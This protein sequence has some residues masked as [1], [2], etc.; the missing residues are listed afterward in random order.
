MFIT[1]RG[2]KAQIGIEIVFAIGITL[3]IFILFI[4]IT[5]NKRGDVSESADLLSKHN[6]C[7]TFINIVARVATTPNLNVTHYFSHDISVKANNR[8]IDIDGVLCTS[9]APVPDKNLIKGLVE[10]RNIDG[11]VQIN[12]VP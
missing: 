7:K 11:T 3:L 5:I 2:R 8:L 4:P 9:I 1:K 6:D 10:I 12:N